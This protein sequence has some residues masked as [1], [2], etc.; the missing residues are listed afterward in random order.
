ME[1]DRI[2]RDLDLRSVRSI[3]GVKVHDGVTIG[4]RESGDRK[5]CLWKMS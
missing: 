1:K 5:R 2:S 3:T 4:D